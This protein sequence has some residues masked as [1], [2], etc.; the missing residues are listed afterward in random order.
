MTTR[1]KLIVALDLPTGDAAT[2]MAERLQD[3][4]GMFK[5]GSE[6]FTAEGPVAVRYLVA[7]GHKVFLDLKFHDIPNTVRAAARE[8]AELGISMV[9]VHASGGRKMME[10]ALEGAR[11]KAGE[12]RGRQKRGPA[13]PG[14][15]TGNAGQ[16]QG[17]LLQVGPKVL[18][19][20]VLTSLEFQDLEELGISGTPIEAVVRLARLAQRAGLDGVVASA[21]EISALRQACGPDFL[22][23][24]P[25]I[26]PVQAATDDQA[27]IATPASA[28]AAGADYLV[29]GRPITAAPDPIAA[30]DAIVAEME[31]SLLR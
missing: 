17:P 6:L 19:V 4:V 30:A 8:A 25:G 1:D 12:S 11:S 22:I 23:V 10:A 21:R 26:R 27:R 20:T 3:H 9:N 31:S 2:R 28:I 15:P 29:V 18:A 7:T 13:L 16:P 24:T 5:V 14:P